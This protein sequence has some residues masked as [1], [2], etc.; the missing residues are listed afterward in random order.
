MTQ[1]ALL[2]YTWRRYIIFL[3]VQDRKCTCA[4]SVHAKTRKT[5]LK[6]KH[7]QSACVRYGTAGRGARTYVFTTTHTVRLCLFPTQQHRLF[8]CPFN[9]FLIRNSGITTKKINFMN[10]ERFFANSSIFAWFSAN[11]MASRLFF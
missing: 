4:M 7:K 8:K 11:Q 9:I 10:N 1:V 3:C 5:W 2:T 6:C